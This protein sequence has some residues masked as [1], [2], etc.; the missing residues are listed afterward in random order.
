MTDK[1]CFAP[2]KKI[3]PIKR[4]IL[5]ELSPSDYTFVKQ[6]A[7]GSGVSIKAFAKQAIMFACQHMDAKP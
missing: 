3:T 2:Q 4:H 5:V 6:L 1:P 7:E